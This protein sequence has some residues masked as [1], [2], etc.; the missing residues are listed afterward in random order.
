MLDKKITL[1]GNNAVFKIGKNIINLA[2]IVGGDSTSCSE[3]TKEVIIECAYFD[4]EIII[5][6]TVLYDIQSDAAYKFERGVDPFNQEY[7]LR[8]FI[9]IVS[10]H[11]LINDIKYFSEQL[12]NIESKKI[13]LDFTKIKNIIGIQIEDIKIIE[14]LENLGFVID[15][16]IINVPSYRSDINSINDI[17]EEIARI[18][19]YDNIDPIDFNIQIF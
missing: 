10:E 4:P 8:R 1:K 3:T 19:G 5:G 14:K 7:V 2:G 12:G 6:K 18:I 17:C 9:Q 16:Q 11:T 15:D 13:D